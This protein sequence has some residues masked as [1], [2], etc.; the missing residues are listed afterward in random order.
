MCISHAMPFY[1]LF[2]QGGRLGAPVWRACLGSRSTLAGV[3]LLMRVCSEL[4]RVY[5]DPGRHSMAR[6][7]GPA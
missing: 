5:N 7:P 2:L 4:R 6:M 1:L 3:V